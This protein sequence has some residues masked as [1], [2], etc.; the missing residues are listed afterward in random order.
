MGSIIT[1]GKPR[2]YGLRNSSMR[3]KSEAEQQRATQIENNTMWSGSNIKVEHSGVWGRYADG[4]QFASGGPGTFRD[5][6]DYV[7]AAKNIGKV[8]KT[9]GSSR[10]P[11]NT[12]K[13]SN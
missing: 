11:T 2:R 9:Y 5:M 13:K 7:K 4:A 10:H 12:Y 8:M 1:D 6:V 3:N